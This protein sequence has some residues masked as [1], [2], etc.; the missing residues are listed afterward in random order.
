MPSASSVVDHFEAAALK[1]EFD[2]AVE[3]KVRE[4]VDAVLETERLQQTAA[5][6]A[7]S[8]APADAA[9][10][11]HKR[12]ELLTSL[13]FLAVG[14][15]GNSFAPA[16][17]AR[18]APFLVQA[19]TLLALVGFYRVAQRPIVRAA[20]TALRSAKAAVLRVTSAADGLLQRMGMPPLVVDHGTVP[21]FAG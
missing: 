15:A 11:Q 21:A 2:A 17:V 12:R 7:P 3:S 16:A 14:V 13:A 10:G 1:D 8:S 19:P 9:N 4:R 18:L 20:G 6:A 5:A